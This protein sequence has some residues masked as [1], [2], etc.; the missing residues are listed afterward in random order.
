MN[1]FGERLEREKA[2]RTLQLLFKA[3]RLYNERAIARV[4]ARTGKPVRVAHTALFPHLD[5]DGT[6]LTDLAA[7]LG[8]T[9]QAAGQLVDEL[10]AMGMLERV[11]DPTDARA[12]LVRFSRRGQRGLLDGLAVL[13]ELEDELR[14]VIG[15]PRMR[16]LHD[17]L[18]RIV[19]AAAPGQREA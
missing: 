2:Q 9:K 14:G 18:A 1:D 13:K 4:R 12:K 10:E 3:A 5:L 6:R 7:R 15:E 11:S 17:A 8:V 16:A 19:A